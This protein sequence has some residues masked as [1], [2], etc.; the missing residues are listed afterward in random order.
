MGRI[1]AIG[2]VCDIKHPVDMSRGSTFHAVRHRTEGAWKQNRR[3]DKYWE[4]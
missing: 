2:I 4:C 3:K 1:G